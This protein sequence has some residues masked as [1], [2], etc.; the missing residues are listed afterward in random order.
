M[1]ISKDGI[2]LEAG[3]YGKD[4]YV[5]RL[6]PWR[7][8]ET[9]NRFEKIRVSSPDLSRGSFSE[10]LEVFGDSEG[11]RAFR[12]ARE[13]QQSDNPDEKPLYKGIRFLLDTSGTARCIT[14]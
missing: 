4:V 9:I 6:V 8:L 10:F 3:N 1:K 11:E 14:E 13:V 7:L 2:V 5:K 12:V